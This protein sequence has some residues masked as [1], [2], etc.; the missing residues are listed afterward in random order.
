[1]SAI[2]VGLIACAAKSP[3][4]ERAREA[5]EDAS[6]APGELKLSCWPSDAM[7][8][9]DGLPRGHC[10]DFAA[11]E[12]RLY[13]GGGEH[14]LEVKKPMFHPYR[15]TYDPGGAKAALTVQLQPHGGEFGT[16]LGRVGET[17]TPPRMR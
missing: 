16:G 12:R 4:V 9:V 11:P 17:V 8:L 3:V 5:L 15:G 14:L 2:A 1:M 6:A 13:V 10:R 7:V